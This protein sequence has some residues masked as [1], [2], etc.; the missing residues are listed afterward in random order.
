MGHGVVEGE[1]DEPRMGQRFAFHVGGDGDEDK[2]FGA[3]LPVDKIITTD[4]HFALK[5]KED[6][7]V[8]FVFEAENI[9]F[10]HLMV[11]ES[12]GLGQRKYP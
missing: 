9:V 4:F 12:R 3:H 2:L 5:Q 8:V 11:F 6:V 10:F 1:Q 7:V